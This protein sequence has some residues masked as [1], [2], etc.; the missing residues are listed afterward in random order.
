MIALSALTLFAC[1]APAQS[2]GDAPIQGRPTQLVESG[3][4]DAD[5]SLLL[6]LSEQNPDPRLRG[7][8][9]LH[10]PAASRKP[11]RLARYAAGGDA[12]PAAGRASFDFYEPRLEGELGTL[13]V[14]GAAASAAC[15]KKTVALAPLPPAEAQAAADML[16]PE[17]VSSPHIERPRRL[18]ETQDGQRAF[19]LL[20]DLDHPFAPVRS[21]YLL[22][23][24]GDRWTSKEMAVHHAHERG[25]DT[26]YE[27]E[28][29]GALIDRF[30]Q[31]P[32]TFQDAMETV[33][34]R[35]APAQWKE[36]ERRGLSKAQV[37]GVTF[38][39]CDAAVKP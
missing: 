27:L 32:P 24:D 9:W 3:F 38:T 39:P 1:L 8:V 30:G 7:P 4:K 17:T 18:L 13:K 2:P 22:E 11:L 12:H 19:V 5:G 23:R 37:T 20:D 26:L 14:D 6:L 10:G 31:D 36:L 34:L 16:D 35:P 28:D 33:P 15:G 29:G 25:H 21:L